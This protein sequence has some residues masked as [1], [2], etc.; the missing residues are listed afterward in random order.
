MENE[1]FVKM[2]LSSAEGTN[3][4]GRLLGRWKDRVK[5]YV[6]ERLV[7]GNG[8]E[9]ARE[10]CMDRER[11][12]SVWC[13]HPMGDTSGGSG[14]SELLIDLNREI[15]HLKGQAAEGHFFL[16]KLLSIHLYL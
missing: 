2:Y 15:F 9:W 1:E 11:C 8:L 3:R 14:A 16:P 7:R 6:S 10:E 5:E 12:R 4:R 13:G